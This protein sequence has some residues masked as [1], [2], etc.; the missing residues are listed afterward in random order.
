MNYV[1]KMIV[2]TYYYHV[3]PLSEDFCVEQRDE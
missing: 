2:V 3:N 1:T